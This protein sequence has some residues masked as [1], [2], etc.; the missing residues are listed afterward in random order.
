MAGLSAISYLTGHERIADNWA[1]YDGEFTSGAHR[2]V[3]REE[4]Y[5]TTALS[6]SYAGER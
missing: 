4:V 6:L 3:R 2:C 5:G 1:P